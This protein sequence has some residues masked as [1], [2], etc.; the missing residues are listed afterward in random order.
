MAITALYAALLTLLFIT[1][2]ANVVVKRRSHRVS[3]GDGGLPDMRH[4]IRAHGNFTEYAPLGLVILALVE[5]RG[6]PFWQI[7]G[8]GAA[9]LTGRLLHAYGL[10]RQQEV[11]AP[12]VVGMVLTF[13]S[14]LVGTIC[15]LASLV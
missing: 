7:H 5:L 4:A 9:L 14:L 11:N 10:T 3:L 2:S 15:L 8:V 12:R 13:T 6:A 1:L